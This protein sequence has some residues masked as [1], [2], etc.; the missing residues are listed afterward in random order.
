M[1]KQRI[2]KNLRSPSEIIQEYKKIITK[3]RENTTQ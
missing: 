3:E 1:I 2:L